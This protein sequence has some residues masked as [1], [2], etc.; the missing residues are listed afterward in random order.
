MI[1]KIKL[2]QGQILTKNNINDVITRA[3]NGYDYCLFELK[4][5]IY[6]RIAF[7]RD[8]SFD[9]MTNSRNLSL[10]QDIESLR[11]IKSVTA[12]TDA[13]FRWIQVYNK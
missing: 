9:I 12:L 6:I 4:Y 13:L 8:N 7:F 3:R 5:S 10:W 11:R 1:Q 2:T